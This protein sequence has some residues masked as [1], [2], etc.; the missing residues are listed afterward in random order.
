M[1]RSVVY[2]DSYDELRKVSKGYR[3]VL[4]GEISHRHQHFVNTCN[5]LKLPLNEG[6]RLVGAIYGS[7]QGGGFDGAA[8]VFEALPDKKV[9]LMT[10]AMTLMATGLVAFRRPTMSFLETIFVDM[11]KAQSARGK[12]QL[13]KGGLSRKTPRR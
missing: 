7:L 5:E 9:G 13:S 8:G 11:R 6:K 1:T 3:E 4:S 2:L 10:L 12:V